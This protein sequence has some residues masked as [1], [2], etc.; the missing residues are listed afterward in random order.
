MT[1]LISMTFGM[2]RSVL[3]F[4]CLMQKIGPRIPA[5]LSNGQNLQHRYYTRHL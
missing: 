4:S 3:G 5:L 1:W 2:C